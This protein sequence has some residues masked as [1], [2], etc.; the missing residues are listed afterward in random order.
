MAEAG[1]VGNKLE[2]SH[3]RVGKI[4]PLILLQQTRWAFMARFH[5][6]SSQK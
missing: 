6:K 5:L 1:S 2:G 4:L 3:G